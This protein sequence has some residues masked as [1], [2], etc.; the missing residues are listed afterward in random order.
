MCLPV[1]SLLAHIRKKTMFSAVTDT[2][3]IPKIAPMVLW[4]SHR[5]PQP[6]TLGTE[7]MKYKLS[8]FV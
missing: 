8:V 7:L 1:C 5:P 6:P 2:F 3:Q 4:D